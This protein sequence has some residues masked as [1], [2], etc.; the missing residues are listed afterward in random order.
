[1]KKHARK[2][3]LNRETLAPMQSDELANVNGGELTSTKSA[4][5]FPTSML[6]SPIADATTGTKRCG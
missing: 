2:L 3:N 1:M 4:S 6:P 5:P